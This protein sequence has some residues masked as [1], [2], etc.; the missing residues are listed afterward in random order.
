MYKPFRTSQPNTIRK[1]YTMYKKIYFIILSILF[2][3]CPIQASS[4]SSYLIVNEH[5]PYCIVAQIQDTQATMYMIPTNLIIAKQKHTKDYKIQI[6]SSSD[7]PTIITQIQDT[8]HITID[9]YVYLQLDAIQEDIG[10]PYTTSTFTTMHNLTDYFNQIKNNLS[11]SHI[12]HYQNYLQS[13]LAMSDYYT[14]YK[15]FMNN[16]IKIQYA[17]INYIT[18]N[19]V[20]IPLSTSFTIKS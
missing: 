17:Y 6:S 18:I 7:I 2:Q 4:T 15:L 10:I 9:H 20:N 13:D 14:L 1:E 12:L 11:F 5:I 19:N 8:F 3:F 16:N